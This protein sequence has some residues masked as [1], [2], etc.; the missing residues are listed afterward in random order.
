M[1]KRKLD[2]I[3]KL[4]GA[5]K[6]ILSEIGE[7]PKREGLLRTPNRVAKAW[8]ALVTEKP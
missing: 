7:D 6:T 1:M 4:E 5:V 3:A 8:Q 2:R